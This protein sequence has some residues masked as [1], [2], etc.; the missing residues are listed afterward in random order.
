MSAHIVMSF[1]IFTFGYDQAE[2]GW[3]IQWSHC[4]DSHTDTLMLLANR[5]Q[6]KEGCKEDVTYYCSKG[7][8]GYQQHQVVETWISISRNISLLIVC[9]DK[10]GSESVSFFTLQMCDSTG[11]RRVHCIQLPWKLWIVYFIHHS[12]IILAHLQ[13]MVLHVHSVTWL[14]RV[15]GTDSHQNSKIVISKEG[16]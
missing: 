13:N 10:C 14:W 1:G 3:V 11:T 9:R 2:W 8:L 7:L 4:S 15:T 16:R 6:R 5:N 12:G